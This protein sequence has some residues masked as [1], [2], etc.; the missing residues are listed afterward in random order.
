MV[1]FDESPFWSNSMA[2]QRCFRKVS[3]RYD[4][5]NLVPRAKKS[6]VKINLFGI[7]SWE[8]GLV[9]EYSVLN[10]NGD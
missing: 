5:E 2:K 3:T 10:M 9:L 6:A 8:L 4:E 1:F 7:I